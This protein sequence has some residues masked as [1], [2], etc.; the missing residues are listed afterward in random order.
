M[1]RCPCRGQIRSRFV[2]LCCANRTGSPGSSRLGRHRL[3]K[4]GR[5]RHRGSSA[6]PTWTPVTPG[7]IKGTRSSAQAGQDPLLTQAIARQW[8]PAHSRTQAP[9]KVAPHGASWQ[10][11]A[12]SP[13]RVSGSYRSCREPRGRTRR[14]RRVHK[15]RRCR[16]DVRM[17]SLVTWPFRCDQCTLRGSRPGA[18]VDRL[19]SRGCCIRH[20][21]EN[22][23]SGSAQVI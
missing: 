19:P 16:A 23:S 15:R 20:M 3:H 7:L 22:A 21:L 12:T 10:V 18:E 4:G 17:G 9:S 11:F 5:R 14:S 1:K 6:K 8:F 13:I 2:V